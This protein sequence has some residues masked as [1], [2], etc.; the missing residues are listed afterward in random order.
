MLQRRLGRTLG[1]LREEAGFTQEYAAQLMEWSDSKLS[2]VENG[3]TKADIHWVKSLLDIYDI[4]GS[5]REEIEE[6]ARDALRP[7]WW[8]AYGTDDRGYVP[9]EDEAIAV[10]E[11]QVLLIP[12][13]LQTEDYARVTFTRSGLPNHRVSNNVA[14]R[15]RRQERLT[16]DRP[17]RLNAII[18]E[19][20][21]RRPGGDSALMRAQLDHLVEAAALP[22]VCLR[23]LPRSVGIHAGSRY[24]TFI[25]LD[26]AEPED[27][28]LMY[29]E[30][31]AGSVVLEKP[32]DVQAGKIVFTD[33]LTAALSEDNSR[34]LIRRVNDEVWSVA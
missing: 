5:R 17:L 16:S 10:S 21:L 23:I 4:G 28:D 24:G 33:L 30:H 31:C 34:A 25:M 26:F 6:L 2:R 29:V 9:L 14:V 22:T 18:E 7:G 11:Y 32:D 19:D 8:K 27:P 12:G 15:M 1:T 3:Q 13:L 20:V